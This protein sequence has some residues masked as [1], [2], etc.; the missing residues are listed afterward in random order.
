[1]ESV[2][3]EG[4]VARR[5]QRSKEIF[6]QV[7]GAEAGK[8]FCQHLKELLR[9]YAK[10]LIEVAL[11]LELTEQVGAG[12]HERTEGRLDSRNGHYCRNLDT[13][14]GPIER[15]RVP[16]PRTGGLKQEVFGRYER[17]QAEVNAGIT[18]AFVCGVSTRRVEEALRPLVGVPV[19]AGTVSRVTKR[20]DR[21]VEAYHKRPLVDRYRYLFLD[22]ITVKIRAALKVVKK[23]VLV[24]YG[25]TLSGQR[26]LIDF[27]VVPSESQAQWEGFL[28]NLQRRGLEGKYLKLITTDGCKGLH[29]AL[30]MVFPFTPRQLCWAH[31]LRNVADK[32]PRKLQVECMKGARKIYLAGNKRQAVRRFREWEARWRRAA[33]EAVACLEADMDVLLNFLDVPEADRKM[34]RTTNF[35]ERLFREVRRRTRPMS[36]FP[37]VD[38]C[39]RVIYSVFAHSNEKWEDHTLEEFTQFS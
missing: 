39:E 25:V 33:P 16:R 14:Y 36:S 3:V 24:A 32:L 1:M 38:S 5:F 35:V 20:L 8:T 12:R 17:R 30:D 31:K 21:E 37:T 2:I 23:L 26:E 22:G 9:G 34:V 13:E 18:K 6:R 10:C 27:R 29:G 28:N 15:I 4:N 19:S 11:D 7:T